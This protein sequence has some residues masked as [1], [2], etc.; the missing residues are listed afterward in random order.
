M[1]D[2]KSGKGNEIRA[3]YCDTYFNVLKSNVSNLKEVYAFFGC[4]G[5][6]STYDYLKEG[7]ALCFIIDCST[8]YRVDE[9]FI[10]RNFRKVIFDALV[11]EIRS[12]S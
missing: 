6:P 12:C 8:I 4:Y 11:W 1:D 3:K 7:E 2:S 9:N 10:G 5:M